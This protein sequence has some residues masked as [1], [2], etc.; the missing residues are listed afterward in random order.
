MDAA[1]LPVERQQDSKAAQ[2]YWSA[3]YPYV[4]FLDG[5]QQGTT[6]RCPQD[7]TLTPGG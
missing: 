5:G 1:R 6:L 3:S 7:L 4:M 2:G